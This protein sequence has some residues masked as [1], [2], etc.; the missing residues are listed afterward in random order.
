MILST[1]GRYAV[2]A[3][4]D[5]AIH[6]ENRPV[7]LLAIAQ[8]QGLDQGY[9]EQIFAKL[10]KSGL[11]NSVKGPGGGYKLGRAQSGISISDI[12][13]SV[14]EN[15]SMTRCQKNSAEG[16]MKDK[17]R[18]HTHHLWEDLGDHIY[19]FLRNI[20]IEDVCKKRLGGNL[21]DANCEVSNG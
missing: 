12:M 11:V 7:K 15:I 14:D 13:F 21:F 20:S 16:C 17:S 4:V 3:L 10:K 18:C 2:M 6:G 19:K 8:R 1:K 5:L 9:L